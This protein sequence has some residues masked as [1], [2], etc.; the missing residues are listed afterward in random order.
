MPQLDFFSF[1]SQLFYFIVF[2]FL[3]YFVSIKV[4]LPSI[5]CSLVIKKRVV[6]NC[7]QN[8]CFYLV[9]IKSLKAK[10]FDMD[11]IIKKKLLPK[12][13]S[14]LLEKHI[15]EALVFKLNKKLFL[16]SLIKNKS[17][18]IYFIKSNFINS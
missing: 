4:F 8:S 2:F 15:G 1:F 13:N 18:P 3:F 5:L 10:L 7:Y 14:L 16:F 11:A 17:K 9:Q 12:L 6:C